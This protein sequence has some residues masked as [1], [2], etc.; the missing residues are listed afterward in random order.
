MTFIFS[1]KDQFLPEFNS[2]I[3]MLKSASD[4]IFKK[5]NFYISNMKISLF[6]KKSSNVLKYV[7]ISIY[8]N[9]LSNISTYS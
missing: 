8:K 3:L 2:F 1:K 5:F 9:F 7:S 4:F 6:N